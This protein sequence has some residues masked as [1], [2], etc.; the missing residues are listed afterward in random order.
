[1]EN[2]REI[3]LFADLRVDGKVIYL[4]ENNSQNTTCLKWQDNI[5]IFIKEM[6][7]AVESWGKILNTVLNF[8]LS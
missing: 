7:V 2:Q 6:D 3:Y 4:K 8:Q 5:K 1:L